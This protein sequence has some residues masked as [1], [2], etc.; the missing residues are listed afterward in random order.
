MN[1]SSHRILELAIK[2]TPF[3]HW[4]EFDDV[5]AY[6]TAL[7]NA[8]PNRMTGNSPAALVYGQDLALPGLSAFRE[9]EKD[10]TRLAFLREYRGI[11]SLLKQAEFI[12]KEADEA[13]AGSTKTRE[14]NVGDIVTYRLK[15]SERT[16]AI[17][18]TGEI[19]Y[20][21]DRS[22]PQRVIKVSASGLTV[23][24]M[25]TKGPDR[26]CPQ[27][28]A[29][30]IAANIPEELR[31]QVKELYPALAWKD[32]CAEDGGETELAKLHDEFSSR[33][34]KRRRKSREEKDYFGGNNPR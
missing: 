3:R 31:K 19:S 22:F 13:A 25:W 12:N 34:R 4:S 26:E 16:K 21:P 29:K 9:E 5:L 27:T 23:R 28:E 8:T 17:H 24:P 11:N 2:T 14:F 18:L 7:Y 6:A 1:E 10:S 30:L 20:Q 32:H 15:H 33:Q